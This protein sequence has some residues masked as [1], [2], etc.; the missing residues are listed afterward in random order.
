MI[1]DPAVT[2]EMRE[3]AESLHAQVDSLS[4]AELD[5]AIQKWDVKATDTGNDVSPAFPFNLMFSSLIGPAGLI[6]GYLR[7]ETAQGIFVN[8]KRLLDFAG[9]R[10]P[11]ACAQVGLAFRN[12]I[13]PR[14]GLLRVREFQQAEIEHFVHPDHKEH[15]K[16]D[17]VKDYLVTLYPE[18]EQ[19]STRI[20]VQMTIQKA[21]ENKIIDNETLGKYW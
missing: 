3:E 2:A 1:G 15:P 16:Y 9:S 11:F 13:D 4:A 7:P 6:Q 10:L 17:L 14:H 12:E 21:V 5:S 18:R 19:L 20:P 8:F